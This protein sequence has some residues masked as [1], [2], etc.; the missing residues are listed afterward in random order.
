MISP[1]NSVAA[2]LFTPSFQYPSLHEYEGSIYLTVTP[3]DSSPS[4]KKRILFGKLE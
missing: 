1:P 3:G 4:R 2:R